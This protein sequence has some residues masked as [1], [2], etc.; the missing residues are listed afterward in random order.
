MSMIP[1]PA[2]GPSPR[3]HSKTLFWAILAVAGSA[4]LIGFA[5]VHLQPRVTQRE[6]VV[7]QSAPKKGPLPESHKGGKAAPV[8]PRPSAPGEEKH[9]EEV[10]SQ[11]TPEQKLRLVFLLGAGVLIG[12]FALGVMI[13]WFTYFFRKEKE[14][15]KQLEDWLKH[16]VSGL[17]GAVLG[18]LG[19]PLGD[20]AVMPKAQPSPPGEGAV[21]AKNG[22]RP[23]QGKGPTDNPLAMARF[24]HKLRAARKGGDPIQ[25][26]PRAIARVREMRL[27]VA[28]RA[29][30]SPTIM[31]ALT[32]RGDTY[33][34]VAGIPV[35]PLAAD[36]EAAA[37]IA[38][39]SRNIGHLAPA[40]IKLLEQ[41]SEPVAVPLAS[42]ITPGGWVWL[43][44]GNIGGRTRAVLI[45]PNDPKIMWVG[46]VSGGIWTTSDG[47]ITWA[48]YKGFMGS[49]IVSCMVLDRNNPKVLFAGTGEGFLDLDVMRGAGIYHTSDGGK[50][51]G[52]LAGTKN[53]DDFKW[54]NRLALSVDGKILLAA[55]RTGLFRATAGWKDFSR[56]ELKLP[57]GAPQP[58]KTEV[59]DVRFH[60]KDNL[61]AVAGG[62]KGDAWFSEDG[63]KTWQPATGLP[64]NAGRVELAYAAADP[65][66]VY[67]SVDASFVWKGQD[68]SEENRFGQVIQSKDGGKSYALRG[69]P[70]HLGGQGVYANCIWA[71]DPS[72][73]NV[74][75]VGGL[76]LYR[77]KDGG[78]NWDDPISDS[79]NS[80]TLPHADHHVIVADPNYDGIRNKRLFFGNDGGVYVADDITTVSAKK[81]W[82]SLN[83]GL[84]IT[85]FYGA[86]G[87]LKSRKIIAGAQDNGA[88][89]YTPAQTPPRAHQGIYDWFDLG[90]DEFSFSGDGG[91]CAADPEEPFFYGEYI[92]LRL[93]RGD[94]KSRPRSIDQTI[95][96]ARS[97]ELALFIAPFMLA[98]DDPKVMFAGGSRLWR[99]ADVRADEPQFDKVKSAL[100]KTGDD[101][102]DPTRT[103]ISAIAV[104]KG[105]KV[106]WV[107]HEYKED[108]SENSGAVFRTDDVTAN[109]PSWVRVGLGDQ[110]GK[111]KLP[112]RHCTRL[113]ID[114]RDSNTVYAL[115]GGYFTNNLWRS[116][117]GG[118]TWAGVG[119]RGLPE[120][121]AFDL[122]VHPDDSKI[123]V[124]GTEVGLFVSADAGKTWSPTSQGPTNCAV[125]QL[126]WMGKTL[127]AVTHG[128]GLYTIDL[129]RGANPSA[130]RNNPPAPVP[131][132]AVRP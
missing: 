87:N 6:I 30:V 79:V 52:Q 66:L 120:A 132:K 106:V 97:E 92:W 35:G 24:L 124:L 81:G 76:D 63:G 9:I 32:A 61:R 125:Y 56:V 4:C 73:P 11:P 48:P 27:E 3:R 114:P 107:G 110:D 121:P 10:T 55:T 96:D 112:E 42:Q 16:L 72:D 37:H 104:Q 100:V 118:K 95:L 60:P 105:G 12:V 65:N 127:V 40:D 80:P 47:G 33:A 50:T 113:V 18:F 51:W 54:V 94:G 8:P 131:P 102:E 46:G 111:G 5:V 45:H 119:T 53:K 41:T 85:Q 2:H 126:F 98:P 29:R 86:A 123:L 15:P 23:K 62:R 130:T 115:Y 36:S 74:L 44:P 68:G 108:D 122:V 57:A 78:A 84:G 90:L 1:L 129:S 67:A 116:S 64:A 71:G 43:G 101:R 21:K 14:P 7:R 117:D 103:L 99:C 58:F 31:A 83:N 20:T 26:M 88:L 38:L 109:E 25:A 17:L 93:H 28:K 19:A 39:T 91:V 22:D 34:T 75:V 77:S 128:R 13:A 69:K 82:R 89:I 49:L 70:G 59:L